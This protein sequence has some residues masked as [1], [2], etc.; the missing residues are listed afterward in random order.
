MCPELRCI[1]TADV[2]NPSTSPTDPSAFCM[3]DL[4]SWILALLVAPFAFLWPWIVF[5][6][7]GTFASWPLGRKVTLPL[8][9]IFG[10]LAM[11]FWLFT[12]GLVSMLAWRDVLD[13]GSFGERFYYYVGLP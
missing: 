1:L 2:A 8:A 13:T 5:V 12:I 7:E 9:A 11:S 3:T 6:P 10:F 4:Q